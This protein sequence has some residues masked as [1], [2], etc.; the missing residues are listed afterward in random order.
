MEIEIVA[1]ESF[2]G[3]PVNELA[4]IKVT[5]LSHSSQLTNNFIFLLSNSIEL[6]WLFIISLEKGRENYHW[7]FLRGKCKTCVL[8]GI[9]N[10]LVAFFV[11]VL[12]S[13]KPSTTIFN[14]FSI[15]SLFLF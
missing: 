7:Q 13:C 5:Q 9:V 3:N 14:F 8:R 10:I 1:G 12:I 15:L 4:N 11:F 6:T 2:T